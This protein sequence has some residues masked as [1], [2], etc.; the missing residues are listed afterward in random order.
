MICAI[1]Y[2]MIHF[3]KHLNKLT[4]NK[5]YLS[6]FFTIEFLSDGGGGLC[7]FLL[8]LHIHPNRTPQCPASY[9]YIY[10]ISTPTERL[11]ALLLIYIYYISTPTERLS[12]LLRY[13]YITYPP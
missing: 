4:T 12:A 6:Y 3:R 2:T 9:I 7:D 13:I 1:L 5:P 8:I 11:S 10:Y